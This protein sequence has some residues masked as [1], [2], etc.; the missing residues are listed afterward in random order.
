[1]AAERDWRAWHQRYDDPESPM[2]R[3]LA[4]V[5]ARIGDAL[6]AA[7][8]GPLRLVSMCAGEGRDVIPVLAGHPRGRDVQARLVELD[9]VLAAAARRSAA[10]AG[11][12]RVEVATGDAGLTDAYAGLVPADVVLACGVFGNVTEAAVERTIA[13][14][15]QL[16]AAGGTVVW[17]RHRRP[18]DLVPRICE[19][20]A[21][22]GFSLSWL[23]DPGVT[24]GVGVH[25]FAGQP[26]PLRAGS[27]MF[28]FRAG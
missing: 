18:P 3:R 7:P 26:Q 1:M 8:T 11:L 13:S 14:C 19:W 15:P 10:A 5:Q 23:S 16:C 21:G 9:P 28:A 4:V 24:F 27:R 20:F 22:Q 17:T 2:A 25:R 6:T 12:D